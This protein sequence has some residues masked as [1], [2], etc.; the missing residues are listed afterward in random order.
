M[1]A[2]WKSLENAGGIVHT[3]GDIAYSDGS[4]SADYDSIKT[5]IGIVI[6]VVDGVATK[7]V[8]LT[9]INNTKWSNENVVTNATYET[10]GMANLTAIQSIDDW[11]TKYPAFKWCD[12]YADASGNSEW[13]L[14]AKYELNQL[15]I[16][17]DT[18]NIAIEKIRIE[19]GDVANISLETYWS[20]SQ[21]HNGSYAWDQRF[22]SG[23]L[24]S[25]GSGDPKDDTCSVRAVRAF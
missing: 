20:S 2:Q 17:R 1:Y 23:K 15:Y 7:I 10:N 4:V 5:P 21:H 25:N 12:D 16:V 13:Y 8:S 18:V 3:I 24:G 22:S 14:P 6:E 19:G 9:E 11:E